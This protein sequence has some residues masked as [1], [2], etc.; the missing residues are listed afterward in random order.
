MSDKF[1]LYYFGIPGRAANIRILF[2][3]A[4]VEYENVV[5]TG[6]K[7]GELKQSGFFPYGKVPVLV[8]GDFKLGESVAI[9]EYLAKK[10]NLWPKS[11]EE[12][13]VALSILSSLSDIGPLFYAARTAKDDTKEEKL[14]I[15]TEKFAVYEKAVSKLL[16]EKTFLFGD[17]LTAADIALFGFLANMVGK[18]SI[19]EKNLL[20]YIATVAADERIASYKPE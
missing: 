12:S 19:S 8:N 2:H 11:E 4:G 16:G 10:F 18:D 15:A 1:Q 6:E 5:L 14:K 13:A 3:V 9:T 17:N 20:T 7:F